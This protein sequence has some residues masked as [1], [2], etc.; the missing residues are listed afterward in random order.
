MSGRSIILSILLAG[1]AAPVLLAAQPGREVSGK[2]A[3]LERGGKQATDAG[4]AVVWLEGAGPA[5][6]GRAEIATEK[7]QFLPR[8]LLVGVGSM[9]AFPNHDPF[10]HNVFSLSDENPFDLGLYRRGEA[11][12]VRLEKPGIVRVYCNVHAQMSAFV[13][14][15]DNPW[16]AQPAGDGTFTIPNVPPGR[17]T[18]RVWHERGGEADREI[19]VTAAGLEGVALTLDASGFK[20]TPHLNKF[21]KPYDN[22]GRR[23]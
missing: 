7:K 17:Y 15:R 23:Y 5:R 9:V 3:I 2:L 1:G 18:L 16:F 8:V 20:F 11:P 6:A 10:S 4:D 22:E 12:S 19:T 14:V 21:G 13:V